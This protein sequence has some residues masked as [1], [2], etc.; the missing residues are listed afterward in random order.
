MTTKLSKISYFKLAKAAFI[1]L[2]L[3]IIIPLAVTDITANA[4][5]TI[6]ARKQIQTQIDSLVSLEN[7]PTIQERGQKNK[8]DFNNLKTKKVSPNF[9][10]TKKQLIDVV[11]LK[12]KIDADV[13]YDYMV[14]F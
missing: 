8:Q 10:T 4:D 13:I 6:D 14:E 9:E 1:I 12:Y 3:S 7:A 11:A 5:C 2:I